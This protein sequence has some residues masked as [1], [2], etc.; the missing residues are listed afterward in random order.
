MEIFFTCDAFEET[1]ISSFILN[2]LDKVSNATEIAHYDFGFV[3]PLDVTLLHEIL[4]STA[5]KYA[6]SLNP[7]NPANKLFGNVLM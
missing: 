4:N 3:K 5:L 6:F 2:N 1:G 7:N